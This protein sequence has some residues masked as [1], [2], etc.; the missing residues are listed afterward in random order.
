MSA[1]ITLRFRYLPGE[2][3]RAHNVFAATYLR[4]D[5]LITP[6]VLLFGTLCVIYFGGDIRLA[7]WFGILGV[8]FLLWLA[9][10]FFVLPLIKAPRDGGLD[11]E[12]TFSDEGVFFRMASLDARMTWS[13]YRNFVVLRNFYVLV[14]A[15]GYLPIPKRALATEAD[16]Q[17]FEALLAAHLTRLDRYGPRPGSKLGRAVA[18]DRG[19]R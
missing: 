18:A 2:I 10:A 8:G 15:R 14:H 17:V 3:R 13:Y 12:Y 9:I 6:G 19:E 5:Y 16:K 4:F 11:F 1:P 7:M